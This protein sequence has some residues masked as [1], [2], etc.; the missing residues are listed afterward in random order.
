MICQTSSPFSALQSS[1]PPVSQTLSAW[2]FRARGA[3]L[4]RASDKVPAKG[5]PQKE[6]IM[7]SKAILQGDLTV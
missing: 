5:A 2:L 3:A 4:A 7:P 1:W 6:E